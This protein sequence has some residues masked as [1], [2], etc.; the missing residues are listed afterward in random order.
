MGLVSAL[1]LL[2]PAVILGPQ[3][4][5]DA[6]VYGL[7][8]IAAATYAILFQ[9]RTSGRPQLSALR[10][11]RTARPPAS[12]LTGIHGPGASE[13]QLNPDFTLAGALVNK[14]PGCDVLQGDALRF[15]ERDLVLGAS[16]RHETRDDGRELVDLFP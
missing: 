15:E 11:G 12:P 3:V 1:I 7:L 16:A 5:S 14:P 6:L 4:L 8:G 10:V 9:A 2:L 13:R